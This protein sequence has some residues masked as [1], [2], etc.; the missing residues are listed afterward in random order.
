MTDRTDITGTVTDIDGEPN[1]VLTRTFVA[2]RGRPVARADR[3]RAAR[4][5]IGRW[6]GDPKSGHVAF[7][8]TAEDAD[9]APR[10]TR[11]SSAIRPAASP[12]TRPPRRARG[13]SGSSS[14]TRGETTTADL[15]AAPRTPSEDVGS[16]GPGWEYY[17]DRL[18][19]V[20]KGLD[21]ATIVWD[22]YFPAM[23]P[24]YQTLVAGG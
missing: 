19:A 12:A 16:I 13:T 8:M 6:E 10:S 4:A 24:A 9:A 11:S 23:Q 22:D 7:F 2:P 5:W 1:L 3:F 21:V 14:S 15:R 17:L 20:H 18:V